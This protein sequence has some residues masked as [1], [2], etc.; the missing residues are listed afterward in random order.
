MSVKIYCG[1]KKKKKDVTS[2]RLL[3]EDRCVMIGNAGMKMCV[4][5]CVCVCWMVGWRPSCE[6]Q[7]AAG[8]SG[9]CGA[10]A[11]QRLTL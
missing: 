10:A 6:A 7:R 2:Q 8:P 1:R 4:M 5:E 11:G 3:K 9:V